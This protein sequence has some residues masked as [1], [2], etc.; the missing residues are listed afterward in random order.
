MKLVPRVPSNWGP[1]VLL[2][3]GGLGLGLLLVVGVDAVWGGSADTLPSEPATT[4]FPAID[5]DPG[6]ADD[7]MAAWERW[8]TA[9]FVSSGT[10]SRVLDSGGAPLEGPVYTAQEPPRRLSVRLGAV[11]EQI[12]GTVARCDLPTEDLIVPDC[13]STDT[14]RG[15]DERVE[16]EMALVVQ[17]VTGSTRIYDVGFG[18]AGCFRVELEVAALSSPWGSW[19]EFCFDDGSGALWSSRTRR[20][21]A[22]DVEQMAAIRTAVTDD[23]FR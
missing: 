10:W 16:A 12:D 21:S 23:D 7:L 20:Q 4:S 2:V 9:T 18:A 19:S 1:R 5:H 15:Y 3:V 13:V 6:A 11:V 14:S 8:R 22:I 17:Y